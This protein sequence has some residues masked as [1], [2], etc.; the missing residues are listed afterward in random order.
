MKKTVLV[1]L[2]ASTLGLGAAAAHADDK[3]SGK[4]G[5]GYSKHEGG[6]HHGKRGG[7]HH[8]GGHMMKRMAKKLG[9]TEAQQA[10][11]K[12]LREAQK[13]TH[14]ALREEMKALHVEMTALDSTSATYDSQVVV[15]ADKKADLERKKFI[16]RSDARQKFE[17]VL[18][19]EQRATLK[20]MKEER[21]N[22]HG[23]RHSK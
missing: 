3:D 17:A 8:S 20:T 4:R 19:E 18:T 23:K 13:D 12:T 22:R 5:H 11:I 1:T 7:R 15:L 14:K 6:K 2:L 10:E 16:Q 21:K 9:L